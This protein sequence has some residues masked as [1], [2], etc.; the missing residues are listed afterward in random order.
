MKK[1]MI[2]SMATVVA[3]GFAGNAFAGNNNQH[4]PSK[5]DPKC[6][7]KPACDQALLSLDL[8]L[9][10]NQVAVAAATDAVAVAAGN[11]AVN[12]SQSVAEFTFA[13]FNTQIIATSPYTTGGACASSVSGAIGGGLAGDVE[14]H[15][16]CSSID[17]AVGAGVGAGFGASVAHADAATSTAVSQNTY[18][19]TISNGIGSGVNSLAQVGANS[20][21]QMGV[22]GNLAT[23]S[24]TVIGGGINSIASNVGK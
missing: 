10:N 5:P 4:C 12:Q 8:T 23:M 13:P 17:A 1:S 3:M 14:A 21:S 11:N 20:P 24:N 18:N 9:K 7:P 16:W 6:D 15:K 2:I 22:A 19:A